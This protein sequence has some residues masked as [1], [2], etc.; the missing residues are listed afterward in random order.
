M[1]KVLFTFAVCLS[2]AAFA[3]VLDVASLQKVA[4]P[5]N[6]RV[7]VAGI[8]PQGDYLLVTD[9]HNQGL[10]KYDLATGATTEIT[11]AAGAGFGAAISV[12]GQTVVYRETTMKNQLRYNEVKKANLAT[13]A[14]TQLVKASRNVQGVAV[15]KD[16]AIAVNNGKIAMKAIGA[17]KAK[18]EAPV[19]SIKNRQLMI[20][21]NGKTEVFSPNGQQF[22]YI[23]QSLSPDGTKVLYFVCGRGAYVADLN[24]K[25][26]ASLGLIRAPKW[27]NNEIVVGMNDKDNGE[28]VTSSSIVAVTLDGTRQTL[29]DSSVIAMYPYASLNGE[30]IA[31]TTSNG[32]AYIININP[33]K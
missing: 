12:D 13:G 14:K 20:T 7:V 18:V 23:W 17:A 3:Q 1:K 27:Y 31:F 21:R 2:S 22:S 11:S 15:D 4:M 25:I 24:G 32:E 33:K 29:T 28:V 19:L 8:S 10:S 26:V 16:A 6:K 5:E 9:N 30:K